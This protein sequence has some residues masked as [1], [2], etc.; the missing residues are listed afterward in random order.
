MLYRTNRSLKLRW[1]AAYFIISYRDIHSLYKDAIQVVF[2]VV[3]PIFVQVSATC[4]TWC[5]NINGHILVTAPPRHIMFMT[6]LPST[7]RSGVGFSICYYDCRD[8]RLLRVLRHDE[9]GIKKFGSDW[10]SPTRRHPP[11]YMYVR[12]RCATVACSIMACFHLPR[13]PSGLCATRTDLSM[14]D[15]SPYGGVMKLL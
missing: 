4:L 7:K 12:L 13:I 14:T 3:F 9:G 11:F 2:D 15:H 5:L 8:Q 6:Y 1:S 10:C